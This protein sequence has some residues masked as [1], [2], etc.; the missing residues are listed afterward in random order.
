MA[1]PPER[2]K[3]AAGIFHLQPRGHRTVIEVD[4]FSKLDRLQKATAYVMRFI[5]YFC[6]LNLE[7]GPIQ[8]SELV[9][10]QLKL[11]AFHQKE[12]FGTELDILQAR[13]RKYSGRLLALGPFYD[14]ET[15]ILSVG[16]RLAQGSY[17]PEITHSALVDG[18]SYLAVLIRKAHRTLLHA[19]PHAILYELRRQYWI[20]H[21]PRS[22]QGVIRQCTT[23]R[24]SMSKAEVPRMVDLPTELI[25]PSRPFTRIGLDFAGPLTIKSPISKATQ[26]SYIFIFVC[27]STKAIHIVLVSAL[28]TSACIAGLKRFVSRRGLPSTIYSDNG[29]N[30]IDARNE[31]TALQGLLNTSSASSLTSYA[32]SRGVELVTIPPRSPHFGGLWEAAIKSCKTLLR[33]A[34]GQHVHTFEELYTVLTKIE[35][36]L[37]SR[38]LFAMSSDANDLAVLTPAQF[39]IG[40]SLQS[41]P[42]SK[43][44]Q[45]RAAEPALQ[46]HWKLLQSINDSF[47]DRWS[48]EYL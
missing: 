11:L 34:I 28:T 32:A 23:C 37:N 29:T 14:E 15:S 25:T 33:R 1:V 27:F 20:L 21:G 2:R 30:F 10:T 6:G 12:Y 5:D 26:M 47:W 48:K 41:L 38:P 45:K 19:G 22:V 24:R 39:L 43:S 31:L 17:S 46:T 42:S 35:A 40:S 4:R 3:R 7:K 16:A 36:S 9:M 13:T 18:K 44:T 8:Q